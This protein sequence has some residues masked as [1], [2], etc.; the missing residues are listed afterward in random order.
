MSWKPTK[1]K[2]ISLEEVPTVSLSMDTITRFQG[3]E[4]EYT[5]PDFQLVG[6]TLIALLYSQNAS[7]LRFY[8]LSG[9]PV[10]RTDI[11]KK[12]DTYSI[13]GYSFLDTS[14]SFLH[15]VTN[16]FY[17][18]EVKEG[19]LR[20][21]NYVRMRMGENS[22]KGAVRL[23]DENFAFIGYFQN[24]LW[25]LWHEPTRILKFSGNYPVAQE[26]TSLYFLPYYNG[27]I[28]ISGNQIAYAS[29]QF[30]Y[31]SSYRYVNKKLTK[32]WETQVSDFLYK[33]K[34]GELVFDSHH[35][36]G[37]IEVY[38]AGNYVYTLYNGY[39]DFS[40]E[41]STNSIIVF[42]RDKG[43]PIARYILPVAISYMKFDSKGAN[44][45]ATYTAELQEVYMVR[46]RL[47][48]LP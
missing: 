8:S 32:L 27:R 40:D 23:D 5:A 45:Y 25:G 15:P 29:Y 9:E 46:F 11:R 31:I 3:E 41:K 30:G 2:L 16:I 37:F 26:Y 10:T 36:T 21:P 13:P 17:E 19:N 34:N 4:Y 6:D 7:L 35:K 24:G 42:S 22:P 12:T 20:L 38:F 1:R 33:E 48:A 47:P 43:E 18:Y 14:F 28:D 39:D 44:A